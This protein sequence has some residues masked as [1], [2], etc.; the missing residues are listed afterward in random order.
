MK[1][2]VFLLMLFILIAGCVE[3]QKTN[4]TMEQ[5]PTIIVDTSLSMPVVSPENNTFIDSSK[6]SIHFEFDEPVIVTDF[7]IDG[8][9]EDITNINHV[10]FRKERNIVWR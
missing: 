6:I 1:T 5:E 3:T 10:I 8:I 4:K 9:S 2:K 7:R